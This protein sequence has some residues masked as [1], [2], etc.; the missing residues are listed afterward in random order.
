MCATRVSIVT[1]LALMTVASP[2]YL[3]FQRQTTSPARHPKSAPPSDSGTKV[4][5]SDVSVAYFTGSRTLH[6]FLAQENS[7]KVQQQQHL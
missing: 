1:S 4:G 6:A 3:A 2:M 7:G 5:L